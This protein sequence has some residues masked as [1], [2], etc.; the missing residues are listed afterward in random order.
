[1][2]K[3]QKARELHAWPPSDTFQEEKEVLGVKRQRN[4]RRTFQVLNRLIMR[5]VTFISFLSTLHRVS[6]A[7]QVS[8][9]ASLEDLYSSS[10]SSRTAVINL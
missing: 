7:L 5:L 4:K 10:Y 9:F 3:R 2:L 8:E 6:K 1:M